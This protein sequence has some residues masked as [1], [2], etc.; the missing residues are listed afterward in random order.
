MTWGHCYRIFTYFSKCANEQFRDRRNCLLAM[1]REIFVPKSL[2]LCDY[3]V[4]GIQNHKELIWKVCVLHSA[5]SVSIPAFGTTYRMILPFC[6]PS[7]FCC[8]LVFG[9]TLARIVMWNWTRKINFIQSP[10]DDKGRRECTC[11]DCVSGIFLSSDPCVNFILKYS[12]ITY[13]RC[14]NMGCFNERTA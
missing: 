5:T 14:V 1:I 6:L 11:G 12:C 4:R 10:L 8:L 3:A 7:S 13:T 2:G 9:F